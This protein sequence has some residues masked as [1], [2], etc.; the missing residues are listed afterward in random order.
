MHIIAGVHAVIPNSY[1][2][3]FR[4][5]ICV[6]LEYPEQCTAKKLRDTRYTYS[7]YGIEPIGT[8]SGLGYSG[9]I[10]DPIYDNPFPK[11]GVGNPQSKLASQIAAKQYQIQGWFVLTA[12]GNLSTPYRTEPTSNT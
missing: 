6:C 8:V 2:D 1:I 12:Y 4:P 5:S 10:S 3:Q 7:Y 11:L 9:P